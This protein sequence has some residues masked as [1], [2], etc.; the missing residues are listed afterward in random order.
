[1]VERREQWRETGRRSDAIA[2]SRCDSSDMV[3]LS[4][5]QRVCRSFLLL[6]NWFS[7]L[8]QYF[9]LHVLVTGLFS[10]FSMV[11]VMFS[12]RKR[13]IRLFFVV[14]DGEY[15]VLRSL[16]VLQLTLHLR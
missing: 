12:I 15:A 7:D 8:S 5:L 6:A 3:L 13:Q 10:P 16:L 2:Q 11:V 1:M 9:C 4:G 14:L